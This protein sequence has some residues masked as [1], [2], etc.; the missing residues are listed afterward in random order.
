MPPAHDCVRE[1]RT[2]R[3][4]HS[5]ATVAAPV[6]CLVLG[7]RDGP[8]AARPYARDLLPVPVPFSASSA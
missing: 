8:D 6:P 4:E 1:H 5:P 7:K 3:E 2:G